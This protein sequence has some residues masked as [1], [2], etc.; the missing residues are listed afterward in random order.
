MVELEKHSTTELLKSG[1]KVHLYILGFKYHN[2]LDAIKTTNPD[3][4]D[5]SSGLEII[6]IKKIMKKSELQK[7]IK[8]TSKKVAYGINSKRLQPPRTEGYFYGFGGRFV[9]ETLIPALDSLEEQYLKLNMIKFL[10][11]SSIYY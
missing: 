3:A 9:P 6:Q 7:L 11:A 2:V 5:I 8:N 4:I 10:L 1:F